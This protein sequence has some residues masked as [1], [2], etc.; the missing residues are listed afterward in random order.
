MSAVHILSGLTHLWLPVLLIAWLHFYNKT[1]RWIIVK[2][3]LYS[4]LAWYWNVRAQYKPS[5][6]SLS[7]DFKRKFKTLPAFLRLKNHRKKKISTRVKFLSCT[8]LP[9][10]GDSYR[11]LSSTGWPCWHSS[12]WQRTLAGSGWQWLQVSGVNIHSP[13]GRKERVGRRRPTNFPLQLRLSLCF[14]VGKG[15]S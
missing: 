14:P 3:L 12:K 1:G 15:L 10:Q 8:P 6:R 13:L 4:N 5:T 9:S 7:Q 11:G 2:V